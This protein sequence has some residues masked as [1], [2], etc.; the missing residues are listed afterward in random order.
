MWCKIYVHAGLT[1]GAIMLALCLKSG[2]R[3]RKVRVWDAVWIIPQTT[4]VCLR[5]NWATRMLMFLSS[6][7]PDL[8]GLHNAGFC[9][10]ACQIRMVLI[11]LYGIYFINIISFAVFMKEFHFEPASANSSY[12]CWRQLEAQGSTSMSP[13]QKA[14]VICPSLA[15]LFGRSST[16]WSRF[17]KYLWK[18]RTVLGTRTSLTL[19]VFLSSVLDS[20]NEWTTNVSVIPFQTH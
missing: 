14:T 16:V 13:I 8:H 7:R 20:R 15:R 9:Y 1:S 18:K 10:R 5:S 3:Y 11:M 12:S 6:V 19:Q 4:S 2:M 17:V